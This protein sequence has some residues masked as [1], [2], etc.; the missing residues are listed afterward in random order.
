M[1]V[2]SEGV[3]LNKR[4]IIALN[5]AMKLERVRSDR[6]HAEIEG[7]RRTVATLHNEISELRSL[8]NAI[9]NMR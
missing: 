7:L 8:L 4:N 2:E 1:N 5:E 9:A 3:I 6:L